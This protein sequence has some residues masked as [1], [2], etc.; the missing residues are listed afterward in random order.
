MRW[1]IRGIPLTAGLAVAAVGTGC[2]YGEAPEEIRV[3]VRD[4]AGIRVVENT[5]DPS[6]DGGGWAVAAEPVLS[7]GTF[8]GDSLYQLFR[9]RGACRLATGGIALVNEGSGEIRIY[10]PDGSF[11]RSHGGKGEGPGEFQRPALAGHLP[12]D[13][14]VVVDFQLRRISLVH[15][16]EGFVRSSPVDESVGGNL[17]PR[18]V[19]SDRSVLVGG[20]FYFSSGDDTELKNGYS[21]PPTGYAAVGLGGSLV[22]D[23]GEFPGS[24]LFMNVSRSGSGMMMFARQIPFGRAPR[25][26]VSPDHFHYGSGDDWEVQVFGPGGELGRII[27]WDRAPRPVRPPDLDA[28][29]QRRLEE[30]EDPSSAPSFREEFREMPTPD[31]MPAFG[32][33]VADAE[34]Y[35]WVERFRG[36]LQD[37]PPRYDILDP[38]GR[39]VG[40]VELPREMEL[41]EIG[42]DYVMGLVRDELDVEYVRMYG[43][44]RPDP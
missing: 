43:L 5:G 3:S 33:L 13:T 30:L 35:L 37:E 10:G 28:L 2:S 11:L 27:R 9:V 26:A 24:E 16:D 42:S 21:R 29:L 39:V 38:E 7:I 23:F 12:G 8:Q 25:T 14:L 32:N 36:P 20:G 15:P 44:D 22:T 31:V 18:G 6:G 34:G 19:F 41:L 40:W 17:F 4:S 1:F